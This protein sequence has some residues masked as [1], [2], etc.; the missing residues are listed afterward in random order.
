MKVKGILMILG[1]IITIVSGVKINFL[2]K[3]N[4]NI[5]TANVVLNDNN[6][7]KEE[8]TITEN[9]PI[10]Q[11]VEKNEETKQIAEVEE[12]KVNKNTKVTPKSSS[13]QTKSNTE[14]KKEKSSKET[15]ETATEQQTNKSADKTQNKEKTQATKT[16]TPSDLEYWCVAGGSHHVAGDRNN[17][18]GYY[19]SWDEAYKAFLNYTKDWSSVQYKVSQCSCGLYYFWAIK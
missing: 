2:T 10:K 12:E 13:A 9:I 4:N 11:E 8:N 7:V 18:H 14:K 1:L 6:V 16:I 19:K 15:Q 3:E 17:E 5:E